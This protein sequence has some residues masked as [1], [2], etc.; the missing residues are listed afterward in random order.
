M[1]LKRLRVIAVAKNSGKVEMNRRADLS[2]PS[3]SGLEHT[4]GVFKLYLRPGDYDLFVIGNETTGMNSAL[5]GEPSLS[6]I[7]SVPVTLPVDTAE[8]VVCKH[9]NI[10][11]RNAA[12]STPVTGEV[13]VDEGLTWNS[14]FSVELERIASKASLEIRKIRMKI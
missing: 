5:T 8:F 9:L 2:D 11:I 3:S 14:A 4:G 6:E 10:R 12:S 7:K 13:S 1:T